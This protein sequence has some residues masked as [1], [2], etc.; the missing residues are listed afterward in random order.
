MVVLNLSV[1]LMIHAEH[2]RPE[3]RDPG[4]VAG[5]VPGHVEC[6]AWTV[7]MNHERYDL[8]RN[9]TPAV[10]RDEVPGERIAYRYTVDIASAGRIVD[11]PL[12]NRR[13]L[14]HLYQPDAPSA[15]R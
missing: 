12:W 6:H 11:L 15:E 2:D 3:I 8:I 7:G 13:V 1:K 4:L 9:R 5:R 14:V 10:L